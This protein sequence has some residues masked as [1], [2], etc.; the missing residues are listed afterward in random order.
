MRG[1]ENLV[2]RADG[3]M[4]FRVIVQPMVATILAL[5][6]GLRDAR[7][8]Q[9]P[10]LWTVLADQSV[11]YQLMRQGWKDVGGVFIVALVLDSIYQILMHSGI[12]P[13]EL[14]LT[15]T[16]LAI[17]PYVIV[18]GLVTR[19]ARGRTAKQQN[20]DRARATPCRDP[21]SERQSN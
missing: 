5:R 17:I 13:L 3:L 11:R 2:G 18:R 19:L 4:S 8:G 12:Y 10:F 15:A 6:S 14:L 16:I 9:P 20:D 1:L 21:Q 7:E